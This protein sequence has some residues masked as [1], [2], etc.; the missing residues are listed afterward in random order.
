VEVD[1]IPGSFF[2][3]PTLVEL[4][5]HR[6]HHQPDQRCY[7]YLVDGENEEIHLTNSELDRQARAIAARLQDL[8]L[9][10]ERA[11]L[12]YPPGLEFVSAFFGCLY[13]GVVAVTAFPPRPNQKLFRIES[14]V[15]DCRTKIALTTGDVMQRVQPMA[16][17]TEILKGMRWLATDQLPSGEETAWKDPHVRSDTLAFL[18]YTSGSTGSPKGVMLTHG[19]LLHNS[20][21][22]DYAFEHNRTGVG[23][24]WLPSY[25]DMGLIGGVLQ[26]LW[27]GKQNILMSPLH[28]L[29]RPLR[30]LQAITKYR[31]YTSGG[32]NFAYDL[33]VR[34]IKPEERQQLDLSSW[35]LAFNGAEPIRPKTLEEFVRA[36][37]PC[38]FR[39][40]SFYPCYGLAEATLI[41]TGGIAADPPIILP[42]DGKALEDDRVVETYADD[43]QARLCVGCGK[44]LPD[45]KVIVVNPDDCTP[46][47][48]NQV[49]EIWVKGPSVAAG[50]WNRP[51]ETKHTF[52]AHVAGTGDGPYL[53]TGDLGFMRQGELFCTGRLKDLIIVHGRNHYP[54]DIE[55]TV[56]NS[57]PSLLPLAGA[58]FCVEIDGRQKLVV[59]HE[60]EKC[61][62][63]LGAEIVRALR[64]AVWQEHELVVDHVVLVR[65]N[66]I[67][68]TTS[69]KIQRHGC[70]RAF[71]D[72]TLTVI[73][74]WPGE[75]DLGAAETLPP[76]VATSTAAREAATVAGDQQS[77]SDQP[78]QQ[79]EP[80]KILSRHEVE[81]GL[82]E[83]VRRIGKERAAN[84]TLDWSFAELGLDS[85]ERIELQAALEDRFGGRMPDDVGPSLHTLREVVQAVLQYLGA[86]YH[87][88][89]KLDLADI[90]LDFYRFDCYPDY[91]QL[92]EKLE[93]LKAL[94]LRSPYFKV[95]Q[96][97]TR[98]TTRIEGRELINFSSYNYLGMSGDPVVVQAVR[99]AVERYGTSVSASRLV[100]GE[101]PLHRELEQAIAS[102]IGTDDAIVFVGGHATNET[103]IGHLFKPGDL[104]LHDALAHNSIL[105]GAQLSGARRRAFP[106]NDWQ[107]LE[108]L[109][110][111]L[112]GEYRRVLIVVE[113]VYSMDGDLAPLPQLVELKKQYKTFLMVDEAHSMG[114]LGEHGR[115][116]A[117]HHDIDPADVDLWMGTL[118]KAL[119]SCGGYIAGS[120]ALIEYLK[121]TAPGFVYSV[122]LSPPNAAAALASL[123]LLEQEPHRVRTLH[124]RSALFLR[125]AQRRGL[126]TGLSQDSPVI[127]VILGNS[128]HA[129]QLSNALF[130]R[131]I[132]VQPILYPAV[133]ESAARLRFFITCTHSAEQIRAAVVATSE[134][135]AKIDPAYAAGS[136]AQKLV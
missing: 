75:I 43:P 54:Q 116:M 111:N 85:L 81:Q 55:F 101:K 37:G 86:S 115:G 109:L 46:C 69:N 61:A 103:T 22:I 29:H 49:G 27:V 70:R 8:N 84:V 65:K 13:A 44:S 128:M 47:P 3:P 79:A 14:I 112:R 40:E 41:C 92:H 35:K 99:E 126:N 36:F 73:A 108:R 134:E 24:F 97:V 120:K 56:E 98:D 94:G 130:E 34:R 118:S 21:L 6:A 78:P 129:L 50:Y 106:H 31:A 93:F 64:Q 51:D 19:N 53:R 95:H 63:G 2:G 32:P 30:W 105:Q 82:L 102:W 74:S 59:V 26:P 28:F 15:N 107:A 96:S 131:G 71:L 68:K 12:L 88:T 23:V 87:E 60:V 119:G 100:S 104:I 76:R 45:Q 113:G 90:P 62:N 1:R 58:A 4:L 77:L 38:G 136:S 10:G 25:H 20:A 125:L 66:S 57:H 42:V 11:L 135:L 72:G 114:V 124:Q 133:E 121:Y 16:E 80:L 33:C 67:P 127:P 7:T 17:E 83:E 123:R 91:K 9:K 89:P 48:D 122:G 132:N 117:Q 110:A 39:R 18:Q 5:R 52:G